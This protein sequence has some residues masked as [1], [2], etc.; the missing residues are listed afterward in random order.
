MNQPRIPLRPCTRVWLLL[1]VLTLITFA[2]GEA[3]L[4][5]SR[6]M[7]AVLAITLVKSRMVAGFFMG[8]RQTRLLWRMIMLGYL[9]VVG[10]MIA[11]A[12][13]IAVK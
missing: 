3:G 11:L 13:L 12:Y 8:L 7:L 10:S 1:L 4:G 5:G 9:A 2:I 6:I